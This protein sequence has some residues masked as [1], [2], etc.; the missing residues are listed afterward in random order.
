V[1]DADFLTSGVS[2]TGRRPSNEDTAAWRTIPEGPLAAYA[3]VCDGMGGHNAGEVASAMGVEIVTRRLEELAA[4][5]LPAG[6]EL[7]AYIRSAIEEANK[8]ILDRGQQIVEQRGMGTTLALAMATRDKKLLVANIGDSRIFQLRGLT[9]EQLS[10]DHTALAEQRR[11]LGFDLAVPEDSFANPFA[12][13]LTRSLGQE[14]K[15]EPDVQAAMEMRPGDLVVVTSDGV[16][17]VL[18]SERLL[19][20]VET[21]VS[22]EAIPEEIYRQAYEAGSR[23]NI[24]VV[25][26]GYGLPGRLGAGHG[27]EPERETVDGTLPLWRSASGGVRRVMPPNASE[28][29]APA[30]EVAPSR[31]AA[32]AAE[33]PAL[34]SRLAAAVLGI[35]LPLAAL[36]VG[37]AIYQRGV[38]GHGESAVDAGRAPAA[39]GQPPATGPEGP[40]PLAEPVPVSAAKLESA[41]LVPVGTGWGV[42]LRFAERVRSDSK[43]LTLERDGLTV[44][45][46]PLA[47]GA[48]N[49]HLPCDGF[50]TFTVTCSL[51]AGTAAPSEGESVTLVGRLGDGLPIHTSF[52]V[53]TRR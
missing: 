23:D 37:L 1:T 20:A 15:V 52:V 43:E 32:P 53:R 50:E 2:R 46:Q 36:A 7:E 18:E 13:A 22:L 9:V 42:R 17:D 27:P 4:S 49:R 44:A 19:S 26:L 45:G 6:V 29:A 38:Q 8:A 5:G 3:L 25:V 48:D 14:Q 21:A 10:V 51:G 30:A 11:A 47:A 40:M 35:G 41:E 24:T 34:R 16:T 28:P 31:P 39:A 33:P 12:H